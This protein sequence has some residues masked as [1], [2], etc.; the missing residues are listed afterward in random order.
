M[1]CCA[2]RNGNLNEFPFEEIEEFNN[3]KKEILLILNN[4][5]NI[6]LSNN[7]EL[8]ELIN[9]ISIKIAKCEEV[10]ES[11]KYK[12]KINPETI[13]EIMQGIKN[14][15]SEL[16]EY[17]L[18]LNNQIKKNKNE[19]QIKENLKLKEKDNIKEIIKEEPLKESTLETNYAFK[20][21]NL[22]F[23]NKN[24]NTT[25]NNLDLKSKK[26][27]YYKKFIK[28]NKNSEIFNN[29]KNISKSEI[30]QKSDFKIEDDINKDIFEK[31]HS[32]SVIPNLGMTDTINII[33]ILENGKKIIEE[34]KIGDSLL[35]VINKVGQ[36][37]KMYDNIDN[38]I[39]IDGDNE[40][41]D[42]VKK[43]VKITEL[44]LS[45]FHFI[46]IKLKGNEK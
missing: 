33:L 22:N 34:S 45:D 3:L 16:K 39:I 18:V 5:D 25:N 30:I 6:N 42:K 41:T 15:I 36:K 10:L 31:D 38:M 19:I 23:I 7:N 40:I 29:T 14:N 2:C 1:G 26:P 8:L 32:N 46:N 28:K 11:L 43:G 12:K 9:K 44:G 35:N 20:N 37:E 21:N 27:I 24:N 13:N 4:K 17:N